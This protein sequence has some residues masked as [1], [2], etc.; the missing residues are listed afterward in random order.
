MSEKTAH[1]KDLEWLR[2]IETGARAEEILVKKYFQPIDTFLKKNARRKDKAEDLCQELFYEITLAARA[3]K[4]KIKET[5][6]SAYLYGAARKKV[7]KSWTV[8]PHV[9]LDGD[10][11]AQNK[12]KAPD[13][14]KLLMDKLTLAELALKLDERDQNILLD[15]YIAGLTSEEIKEKYVY[16]TAAAARKDIERIRKSLL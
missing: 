3:G 13:L 8:P 2:E 7:F 5:T 14:E 9:S 15:Y 12:L 16:N 11:S 10:D 4:I 1:E 6:F